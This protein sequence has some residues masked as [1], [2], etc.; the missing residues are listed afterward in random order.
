MLPESVC[1]PVL[2]VITRLPGAPEHQPDQAT[3]QPEI[4]ETGKRAM[5]GH[6][7]GK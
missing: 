7:E 4:M 3:G 6:M 5:R 1:S 2:P